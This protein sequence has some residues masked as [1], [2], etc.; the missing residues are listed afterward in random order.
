M[1]IYRLVHIHLPVYSLRYVMLVTAFLRT[2]SVTLA[3]LENFECSDPPPLAV[4]SNSY[5]E[6]FLKIKM[7]SSLPSISK[8]SSFLVSV[9]YVCISFFYL[10]ITLTIYSIYYI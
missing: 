4:L 1:Y 10:V 7:S 3:I 5:L 2:S 6:G 9:I 8:P